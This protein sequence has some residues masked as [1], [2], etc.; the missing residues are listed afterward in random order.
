MTTK[1]KSKIFTTI[2]RPAAGILLLGMVTYYSYMGAYEV[3][4]GLPIQS[5]HRRSDSPIMIGR[6]IGAVLGPTGV[7]VV[8]SACFIWIVTGLRRTVRAASTQ[9]AVERVIKKQY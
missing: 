2:L 6:A 7:L 8:A 5:G 1:P 9:D 4:Q 3:R